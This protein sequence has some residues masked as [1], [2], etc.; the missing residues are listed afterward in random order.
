[1]S[2]SDIEDPQ[3]F[4]EEVDPEARM[5]VWVL[6]YSFTYKGDLE[7]W[8]KN[9]GGLDTL[10]AVDVFGE[11]STKWYFESTYKN[12]TPSSDVADLIQLSPTDG[13]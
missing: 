11:G 10:I 4:P 6:P 12:L 3:V 13:N 2:L 1:M 7:L 5:I 9:P 8:A